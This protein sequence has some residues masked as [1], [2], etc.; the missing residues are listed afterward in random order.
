VKQNAIND[1][2]VAARAKRHGMHHA[3]KIA[4]EARA[5]GI[6]YDLAYAMAEQESTSARNVFGSDPTIFVGA[7]TV[8]K[9]KY[10][11][12]RTLRRAS[13][14]RLMQGVGPL[15]LTW[16]EFQDE[17]DSLGGCWRPRINFRV[18]FRRLRALIKA[19]GT[20]EGIRRYN[21]SGPR[22]VAYSVSVRQKREKWR[23]RLNP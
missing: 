19:H 13:G 12:Y 22:A 11:A 20:A 15:Q 9:K 10:R 5:A 23:K 8:T 1:L 7:G 21:G 6:P 2:K 18:G 4:Q 17:A 14:N 3:V 16:W